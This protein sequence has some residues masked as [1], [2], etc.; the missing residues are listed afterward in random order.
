MNLCKEDLPHSIHS[1]L[2]QI[3]PL[4]DRFRIVDVLTLVASDMSRIYFALELG[5][6]IADIGL[7]LGFKVLAV[8]KAASDRA[9]PSLFQNVRNHPLEINGN[10][11]LH[12][13]LGPRRQITNSSSPVQ[14]IGNT[15]RNLVVKYLIA[16]I[17]KHI[18]THIDR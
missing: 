15:R 16:G 9:R 17:D 3:F 11:H 14:L 10:S 4:L 6:P 18:K 13:L 7:P 12:G 1:P 5:K 2:L 8:S